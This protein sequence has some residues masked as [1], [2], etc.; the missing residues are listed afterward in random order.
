MR[1]SSAFDFMRESKKLYPKKIYVMSG[2]HFVEVDCKTA[3]CFALIRKKLVKAWDISAIGP[4][5]DHETSEG[6]INKPLDISDL[7]IPLTDFKLLNM[8]LSDDEHEQIK[9]LTA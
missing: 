6:T 8:I 1:Y 2:R 9:N 3:Y 4:K 7:G 5:I